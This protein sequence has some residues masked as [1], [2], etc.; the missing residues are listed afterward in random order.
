VAVAAVVLVADMLHPLPDLAV[1]EA[2]VAL[3][4]PQECQPLLSVLRKL[5]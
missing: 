3:S 4:L 5:W 2:A 1:L